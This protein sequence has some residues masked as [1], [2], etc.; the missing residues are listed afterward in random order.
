M[1][2]KYDKKRPEKD[3]RRCVIIGLLLMLLPFIYYSPSYEELSTKDIRV[4]YVGYT[5]GRYA[6]DSYYLITIEGDSVQIRGDF[7]PEE[8]KEALQPNTLVTVKY[9]R[10]MH[11]L[12]M[13]DYIYELT[14]NGERL[15]SYDADTQLE[16]HLVMIGVGILV[17]LIGFMFYNYETQ[18]IRK[19]M[20]K[21]RRKR[22]NSDGSQKEQEHKNP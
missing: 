3:F 8:L 14:C 4:K 2:K 9:Y 19:M 21:Y 10:G 7:S 12:W 18:F 16:R 22:T 11:Y 6:S 20:R 5:S 17:M 13:T 15:V 1:G